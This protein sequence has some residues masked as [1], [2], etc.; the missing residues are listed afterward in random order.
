MMYWY[1]NF[2]QVPLWTKRLCHYHYTFIL[3]FLSQMFQ[4]F[5]WIFIV[6]Y[7]ILMPPH[8]QRFIFISLYMCSNLS[9]LLYWC[10]AHSPERS[11]VPATLQYPPLV[12]VTCAVCL[13]LLMFPVSVPPP[14]A[15]IGLRPG[16]YQHLGV[17][18]VVGSFVSP[19][20]PP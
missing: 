10:E 14:F 4:P 20:S 8:H 9:S 19:V 12:S 16:P 17:S 13:C 1:S 3:S 6:T 5:F 15:S 18:P 11:P 7:S 2:R